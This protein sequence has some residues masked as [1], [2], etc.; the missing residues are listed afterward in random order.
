MKAGPG[1]P[2]GSPNKVNKALREMILGA[3][4]EVGGVEYLVEQAREN[5]GPFLALV[6]KCLPK[7]V[8]V[9]LAAE[10]KVVI[11]YDFVDANPKPEVIDVD[12]TRVELD[13]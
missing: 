6:G 11:T 2:K 5:P 10:T 8:D 12:A 1:R 7:N 9:S 3:L 4:S 13:G